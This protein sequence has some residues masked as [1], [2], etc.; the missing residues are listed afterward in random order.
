MAAVL[1]NGA[2][3]PNHTTPESSN[4]L[5]RTATPGASIVFSLRDD[6][7]QESAYAESV[8]ALSA[9]GAWQE[10]WTSPDVQAR[11]YG[12]EDVMHRI[13]VYQKAQG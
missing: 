11:P 3:T 12:A 4:G 7:A 9:G 10:T 8:A 13:N 1:C 5:L 2:I 6:P